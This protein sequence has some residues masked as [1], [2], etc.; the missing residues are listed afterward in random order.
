METMFLGYI[1]SYTPIIIL[2]KQTSCRISSSPFVKALRSCDVTTSSTS[3]F[4][5]MHVFTKRSELPHFFIFI[6][7][8]RFLFLIVYAYLL[9]MFS[10]LTVMF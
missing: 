4:Q 3:L 9:P 6:F 8:T 5:L 10:C 7:K 1:Y 2:Y